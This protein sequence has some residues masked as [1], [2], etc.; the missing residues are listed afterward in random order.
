MKELSTNWKEYYDGFTKEAASTDGGAFAILGAIEAKL[1]INARGLD[2][3][4]ETLSHIRY[5]VKAFTDARWK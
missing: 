1:D 3:D 5:M 4:E 2:T